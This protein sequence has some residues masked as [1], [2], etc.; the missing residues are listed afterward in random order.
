VASPP[1]RLIKEES[2]RDYKEG[3]E[4]KRKRKRRSVGASKKSKKGGKGLFIEGGIKGGR[5]GGEM[6]LAE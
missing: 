6:E 5:G 1:H 4:K 3:E 2:K